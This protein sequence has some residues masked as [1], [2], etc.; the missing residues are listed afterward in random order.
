MRPA[1]ALTYRVT[2]DVTAGAHNSPPT[3]GIAD[4]VAAVLRANGFDFD[5]DVHHAL[6]YRIPTGDGGTRVQAF[7][8]VTRAADAQ[9]VAP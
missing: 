9:A 2:I 6:E 7:T 8:V 1:I 5:P 3:Q 4:A